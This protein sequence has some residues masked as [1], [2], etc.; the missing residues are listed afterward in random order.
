[1]AFVIPSF[2]ILSEKYFG[3]LA[4]FW[5]FV[6]VVLSS[7]KLKSVKP[8][9]VPRTVPVAPGFMVTSVVLKYTSGKITW[10]VRRT[11]P[12]KTIPLGIMLVIAQKELLLP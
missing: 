10:L 8:D 5:V 2:E 3:Y 11:S 12:P 7:L 9:A 6:V 1:M 4:P